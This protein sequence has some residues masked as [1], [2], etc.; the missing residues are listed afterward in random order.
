MRTRLEIKTRLQSMLLAVGTST[1]YTPTRIENAIDDAYLAV[2][3]SKPWGDIQKGFVE[4]TQAN[5]N[6]YDYPHNCQSKSI[7]KISVD[8]VSLYS[9]WN[10]EDFLREAEVNPTSIV[11]RFSEYGRQ[12]FI[13]PTPTTTGVANLIFWGIIQA[14]SL[15]SDADITMFTD[16][17]DI[18]N[19]A[20]M[21][22]AYADMVQSADRAPTTT[23]SVT[24]S[25]LAIQKGQRIINQEWGKIA[26][27]QQRELKNRPH[28]YVPDYFKTTTQ[29][30]DKNIGGFNYE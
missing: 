13:Y 20:V 3:S 29:T 26:A 16:W 11:K 17:A 21:Q 9:R 5:Q 27:R 2:A 8:G 24:L 28:F 23:K 14:N 4:H 10:F 6:Y 18:L 25:D 7:F 12:I 22:F 19:E 30:T 1:Y 15:T